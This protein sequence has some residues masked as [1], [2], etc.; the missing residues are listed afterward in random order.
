VTG[1]IGY[2]WDRFLGHVKGFLDITATTSVVRAGF[3][4]RFGG[5]ASPFA[6]GR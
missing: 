2:A 4:V 3:N 5:P 6:A 1:R